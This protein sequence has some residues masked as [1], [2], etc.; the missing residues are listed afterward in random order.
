MD[1]FEI[2][3]KKVSDIWKNY[4]VKQILV[5][6]IETLYSHLDFSLIQYKIELWQIISDA[7]QP[8]LH[9]NRNLYS[10]CF[11]DS[12][13]IQSYSMK[14]SDLRL[15]RPIRIRILWPVHS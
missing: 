5:I 1:S 10:V 8:Y 14:N 4:C 3:Y 15:H 9:A 7:M 2:A 12:N 6:K 13:Y 11:S